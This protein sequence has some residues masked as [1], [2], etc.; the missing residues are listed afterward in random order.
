LHFAIG[1]FCSCDEERAAA[2]PFDFLG[3]PFLFLVVVVLGL[4]K[5]S[6]L[7]LAMFITTISKVGLI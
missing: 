4:C 7:V 3:F 5:L 2:G 1:W 6:L